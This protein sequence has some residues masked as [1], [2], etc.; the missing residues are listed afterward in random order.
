MGS[1]FIIPSL[2]DTG[3]LIHV[4]SYGQKTVEIL[5][6]SNCR[7]ADSRMSN[8]AASSAVNIGQITARMYEGC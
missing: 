4:P 5:N 7:P 2:G 6:A 1:G 8:S 3:G